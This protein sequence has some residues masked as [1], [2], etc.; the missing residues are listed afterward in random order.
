MDKLAL[1]VSELVTNSLRHPGLTAGE[2]IGLELRRD[3]GHVRVAVDDAGPGFRPS[4]P[5][6]RRAG[7]GGFGLAIVAD[8]AREWGVNFS[9]GRFT[10]WCDVDVHE[11]P[12]AR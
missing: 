1:V 5:A 7:S 10:V 12:Q 8:L 11:A 3:N 4:Q 2:P 6:R 9:S